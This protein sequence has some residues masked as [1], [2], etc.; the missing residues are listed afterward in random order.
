MDFGRGPCR[1]SHDSRKS[2]ALHLVP[3]QMF[4][5]RRLVFVGGNTFDT[6]LVIIP[7]EDLTHGGGGG[8]TISFNLPGLQ[9][10]SSIS[11]CKRRIML[12]SNA[13]TWLSLTFV[14][15]AIDKK[16]R[17]SHQPKRKTSLKIKFQQG[18]KLYYSMANVSTWPQVFV[19]CNRCIALLGTRNVVYCWHR[20][21]YTSRHVIRKITFSGLWHVSPPCVYSEHYRDM[22]FSAKYTPYTI[23]THIIR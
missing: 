22:R 15:C 14:T 18:L 13:V 21:F 10:C 16:L 20:P 5:G 12:P 4:T 23:P 17:S 19:M 3:R 7:S 1:A 9:S 6:D 8:R 2:S 11:S